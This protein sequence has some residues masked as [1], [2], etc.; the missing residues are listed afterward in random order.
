M[1]KFVAKHDGMLIASFRAIE[2]I[3]QIFLVAGCWNI[4]FGRHRSYGYYYQYEV[5]LLVQVS[6]REFF[7]FSTSEYD[8]AVLFAK[9]DSVVIKPCWKL[10]GLGISDPDYEGDLCEPMGGKFIRPRRSYRNCNYALQ[11]QNAW[12]SFTSINSDYLSVTASLYNLTSTIRSVTVTKVQYVNLTLSYRIY[13]LYAY[14]DLDHHSPP[15]DYRTTCTR[16]IMGLIQEPKL[17]SELGRFVYKTISFETAS[18]VV[19]LGP[20]ASWWVVAGI[21][22]TFPKPSPSKISLGTEYITQYF[23]K[24][25]YII[26]TEAPPGGLIVMDGYHMTAGGPPV[27]IKHKISPTNTPYTPHCR[28]EK[29]TCTANQRC[30]ISGD[31]VQIFYFPATTNATRDMCATAPVGIGIT[32]IVYPFFS[33]L[34]NI[35]P[36]WTPVTTGP[37]TVLP[38]NTTW[39][40]GNVYISLKRINAQCTWSGTAIEVGKDHAGEILTMAPSEVFS[41]RA[42]PTTSGRIEFDPYAYSFNFADLSSPYPWSAWDATPNCVIDKC[43]IINGSYNPWLAVPEAIRRLDPR[44]ATCDLSLYGLY[45]PPR[46]LSSV[47]NI[48][49]SPT[50]KGPR[51]PSA[52]PGQG[53]PESVV[54]PTKTPPQPTKPMDP[55]DPGHTKGLGDPNDPGRPTNPTNPPNNPNNPNNSKNPTNPNNPGQNNP[56]PGQNPPRPGQTPPP[57]GPTTIA[58]VGG[59][60]VVVDPNDPN[61]IIVGGTKTLAPGAPGMTVGGGTTISMADP[62]HIIVSGPGGA[63]P[64]TINIPQPN[65]AQPTSGVI[66]TLPNGER[67]TATAIPGASGSGTSLIVSGTL[68]SPGGPAITL[69]N[70]IVISEAPSGTGVIVIDPTSGATSTLAFSSIPIT[71]ANGVT[72]IPPTP[73][74]TPGAVVTIGGKPYTVVNEG[75]SMVIPELGITLYP[76]GPA[77]TVNGTVISDAGTGVVVGTTTAPFSTVTVS[78]DPGLFTGA[79]ARFGVVMGVW[80]GGCDG[81]VW[82]G[83]GGFVNIIPSELGT[84]HTGLS[85]EWDMF[86]D[87]KIRINLSVCKETEARST[88]ITSFPKFKKA[89]YNLTSPF[90]GSRSF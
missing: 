43:Q 90:P 28:T 80:V 17:Y 22:T 81:N 40:S 74:P 4:Y 75:G 37:Y 33:S 38:G 12:F 2:L 44:W 73:H 72:L 24:G 14:R 83:D 82:R 65:S 89:I 25:V 67:V 76:G 41:Q 45:D 52:T 30:Q 64:S 77:S 88:D 32:T 79:A 31:E 19:S 57:S 47:G 69:P 21:T 60:P 15:F 54:V 23:Q 59:S 56:N 9:R 26:T 61:H 68:L 70:G 29:P 84:G 62:G 20:G 7:R 51:P 11:C 5:T 78:D 87:P 6:N 58:T 55:P 39:Y 13:H 42:Y 53:P 8:R 85:S 50:S 10:H 1:P 36:A 27:T 49:A 63:A 71:G 34:A 35:L 66:I 18:T 48:F 16:H 3:D 86:N 46:A